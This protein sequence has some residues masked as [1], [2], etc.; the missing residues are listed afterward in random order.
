MNRG[1]IYLCDLG[2]PVG[3]EQ[4]HKRPVLIASQ[5]EM[6]RAGIPIVIPISK[7]KKGYPTHIELEG[8]LSTT[9]YLQCEQI[10]VA[11]VKR[12]LHKIGEVDGLVMLQVEM[13]L[14]R[15]LGL[16]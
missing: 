10:R 1:E 6:A 15:M 3:H 14:K 4:G 13:M 2:V 7:T 9:S 11:S 5:G 8:V 16:H 12:L